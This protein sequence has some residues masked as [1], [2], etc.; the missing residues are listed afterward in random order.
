MYRCYLIAELS[1]WQ[2]RYTGLTSLIIVFVTCVAVFR[3]VARLSIQTSQNGSEV[4]PESI[5][6]SPVASIT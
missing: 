3:A 4:P 5:D 2:S 1:D 6:L